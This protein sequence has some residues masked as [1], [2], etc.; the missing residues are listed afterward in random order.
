MTSQEIA[1]LW[2]TLFCFCPCQV[3]HKIDVEEHLDLEL[4][5]TGQRSRKS[6][7]M[8]QLLPEKQFKR[9]LALKRKS[10]LGFIENRYR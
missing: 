10:V 7:I 4:Q 9:E 2:T 8:I 3:I 1:C 6:N 5:E